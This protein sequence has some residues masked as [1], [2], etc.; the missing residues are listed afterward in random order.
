M[1]R[2]QMNKNHVVVE[3]TEMITSG[4]V[5]V[6]DVE[7]RFN[8]DWEGLERIA[9]FRAGN[10]MIQTSFLQIIVLPCRGKL[11]SSQA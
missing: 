7:F 8:E 3:E 11:W 1:F 2:L 5:N 9:V 10:V 4:S 6:Y